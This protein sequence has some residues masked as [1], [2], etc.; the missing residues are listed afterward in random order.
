M[1]GRQWRRHWRISALG[2]LLC[3]LAAVFAVEAKVAWY[4]PNGRVRVELSSTKLQAADA[5]R[6]IDQTLAAPAPVPHF[7]VELLL[8]LSF[9]AVVPILF[10]PRLAPVPP[11]PAWTSFSPPHFFRPPPRR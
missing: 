10:I 2:A 8:F 4:S 5:T 1:H 3:V 6:Q 7:P 11:A 9:A